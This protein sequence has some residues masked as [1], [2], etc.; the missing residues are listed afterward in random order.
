MNVRM[1]GLVLCWPVHHSNLMCRAYESTISLLAVLMAHNSNYIKVY[2][3]TS[4][5]E[6]KLKNYLIL[7]ES[8]K[9]T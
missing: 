1:K 7:L 5:I 9:F 8:K 2:A 3:A 6:E 4:I